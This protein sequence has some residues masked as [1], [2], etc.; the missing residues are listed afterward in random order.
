MMPMRKRLVKLVR[1]GVGQ[2]LG[3]AEVSYEQVGGEQLPQLVR[4]KLLEEVGE[5]LQN[6]TVGELADVYEAVRACCIH[7]LGITPVEW[8]REIL[9][10]REE[11]GAFDDGT[12]MYVITTA[13]PRH[14]G[15]HAEQR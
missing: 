8:R 10:K 5:Y 4:A 13:S 6:P 2:F 15:E 14:E 7:D 11:R 12:G 3:S 9:A 1:D